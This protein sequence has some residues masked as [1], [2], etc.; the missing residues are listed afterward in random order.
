MAQRP[1]HGLRFDSRQ[2][3]RDTTRVNAQAKIALPPLD[4]DEFNAL[5]VLVNGEIAE[6]AYRL[7]RAATGAEVNV[8]VESKTR[9]LRALR[10][11]R[12]KV[13]A[14][15]PPQYAEAIRAARADT[16]CDT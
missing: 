13:D 2:N 12:S 3:Q 10:A 7:H 16:V 6:V 8:A 14:A 5:D 9:L 11:I 1:R 4:F 15:R